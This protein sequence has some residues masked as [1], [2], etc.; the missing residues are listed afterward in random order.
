MFLRLATLWRNAHRLG[1]ASLAIAALASPAAFEPGASASEMLAG[2]Y[3]GAV[4]R[5]VDGDTI[6]VRVEIWLQQN[7]EVLVRVRGIDAPE[8]RGDCDL[9][10]IRAAEATAA[11]QRLVTGGVVTLTE[12]EGD[13]FYGRV[14]ADVTTPQGANVGRELVAAGLARSYDGGT[15]QGWCAVGSVN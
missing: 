2:P 7:L 1:A 5:V 13:K 8:L 11:L 6:A 10:R 4:E 12:I 9:E 15:R 14:V 3:V